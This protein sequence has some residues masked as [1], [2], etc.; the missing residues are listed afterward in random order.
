MNQTQRHEFFAALKAHNPSPTTELNFSS[1]FELLI[2]PFAGKEKAMICIGCHAIDGNSTEPLF[3]KLAGQVE[4][5][6]YKQLK[7]YKSALRISPLMAPVVEQLSDQDMADIAAYYA[8]FENTPEESETLLELGKSIYRAGNK[9]TGVPACMACHGPN[10]RGM[11]SAQWPALSGQ[12]IAYAEKQLRDFAAGIRSNDA[13]SM[14]R[15]I[16]AR[17]SE[18]ELTAVSAYVAG[19]H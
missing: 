4:S 10:G 7:D 18:E 13:N 19:L 15:D 14:M 1:S 2:D 11:P 6:L 8:V 16:S 12:H 5:Y 17:L 9:K 3:P